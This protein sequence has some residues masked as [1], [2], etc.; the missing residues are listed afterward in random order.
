MNGLKGIRL[1]KIT[2]S[3]GF[4]FRIGFTPIYNILEK[5]TYWF[6]PKTFNP[7]GGFSFGYSFGKD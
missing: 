2:K 1:H 3:K 4:T 6:N 7:W 5:E